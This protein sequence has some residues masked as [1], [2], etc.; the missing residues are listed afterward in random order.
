M[1]GCW[2]CDEEV[3]GS[4]AGRV[5]TMPVLQG[6]GQDYDWVLDLL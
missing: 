3:L 2:T 5:K 4:T 6:R 1:V